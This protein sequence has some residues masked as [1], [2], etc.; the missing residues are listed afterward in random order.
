MYVYSGSLITSF[1]NSYQ[2]YRL[3][4][5]RQIRNDKIIIHHYLEVH[6]EVVMTNIQ[7]LFWHLL[8]TYYQKKR[9]LQHFHN[10]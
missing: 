4:I 2:L 7:V 8:W 1:N 6:T 9:R 10:T 5:Q 3:G